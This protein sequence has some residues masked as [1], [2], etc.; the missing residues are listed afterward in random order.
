MSAGL[1]D[2]VLHDAV[3]Y[4]GTGSPP[5]RAD[6][7]VRGDRIAAIGPCGTLGEAKA[8]RDCGGA[9]LAPG[10]VDS[11][12][13]DD[14]AVVLRPAMLPK[15]SQ[16]VTTV[17]VGN[18]GISASPVRLRGP[19]PDPLNLLGDA[20]R[21]RYPRFADYAR[22]VSEARPAVNVVA[23]VG[24]TALRATFLD[25]LSR[26]ATAA[27]AG[28]MREALRA[29]LREGAAGLSTGL[30]YANA[31]AAGEDEVGLLAEATGEEGGVYATHMRTEFEGVLDAMDEAARAGR[32]GRLPVIVSHLKCAGAANWGRSAEVLAKLDELR[33]AGP[34][35]CDCYPYAAGSSTLDLKQVTSDFPI[36]ITWSDPHPAMAG[37]TLAEVA[38]TWG[39]DLLE[40]AR[41]LRPAGA[42]Y[43]NMDE[44]DVRRVLAHPATMVGS[45][46]LPED[47]RP[48]P[49]LW[50]AFPRVLAR[51]VRELGL[52]SLEEAIRKMTGLTAARFGLKDRGVL[53]EGAFADLVLFDPS[54]IADRALFGDAEQ[55][56]AGI[57]GVWVNGSPAW[58]G[59][60]AALSGSGR[61]LAREGRIAWLQ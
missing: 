44:A 3:L 24:H 49:R 25:D 55:P 60:A 48:H 30:A 21:F 8:H 38:G 40:A 15:I 12:T 61:F 19:V 31:F 27:Q 46:G 22:A 13:H 1:H 17:V 36:D 32:R 50:G 23:L 45:D 20:S 2:L 11:H 14:T 51:Y 6:L 33:A 42:V 9:A 39:V 59:S 34:V 43:H 53:G 29:A 28:A 4:D 57:L 41:R 26:P 56:A 10:F 54:R 37:R 58:D 7:A 52:L 35:G 5:R 16:G 47:P 18:C